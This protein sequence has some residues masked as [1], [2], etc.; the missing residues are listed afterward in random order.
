MQRPE[1]YQETE[2]K[3]LLLTLLENL[4]NEVKFRPQ[5]KT[6]K[7]GYYDRIFNG[8]AIVDRVGKST[9]KLKRENGRPLGTLM[10]NSAIVFNTRAEDHLMVTLGHREGQ[11]HLIRIQLIGSSVKDGNG[12]P[13]IHMSVRTSPW[14]RPRERFQEH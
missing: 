7:H 1:F 2:R 6:L 9:L 4:E 8:L 13:Q 5:D 11:W 3:D 12:I 14:K 10:V